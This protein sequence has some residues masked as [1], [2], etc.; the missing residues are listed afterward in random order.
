MDCMYGMVGLIRYIYI[1]L[2]SVRGF[3]FPLS[4]SL[5]RSPNAAIDRSSRILTCSN[6][7]SVPGRQGMVLL[8]QYSSIDILP[9]AQKEKHT[10]RSEWIDMPWIDRGSVTQLVGGLVSLEWQ[11]GLA[12]VCGRTNRRGT[13][14]HER[15][16][17]DF[18][19]LCCLATDGGNPD[20]II[21]DAT[22]YLQRRWK[23]VQRHCGQA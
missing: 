10:E 21:C 8:P 22:P 19:M 20:I 6:D 7:N 17:P 9:T 3:Q 12:R 5:F 23:E 1:R 14:R 16:V 11:E 18:F 13:D 2:D 15:D 4:L